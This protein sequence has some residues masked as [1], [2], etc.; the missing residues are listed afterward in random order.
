MSHGA[1]QLPVSCMIVT[2]SLGSGKTTVIKE[3]MGRPDMYGTALIV[4]EF[5]EV[6]LDH[7]LVSSAV[8][9]T[10]LMENG[11]LCCSLRG[12]LVDTIQQLFHSVERA[13]T[14]PF[15]RLIVETTGLADPVP[16]IRDLVT[17]PVLIDKVRLASVCTVVDGLLGLGDDPIAVRQVAQADLCILTKTDLAEDFAVDSIRET[18]QSTNPL[19]TVYLK[20]REPL[21][22][23]GGLFDTVPAPLP[24]Q[25]DKLQPAERGNAHHD[26]HT[27]IVSWSIELDRPLDWTVLSQWFDYLFSL[28]AG[29]ILRMK[30]IVWVTDGDLPLLVQA[31]GP[32]VSPPEWL[33]AWPDGEKR[34]RLVMISETISADSIARSFEKWVLQKGVSDRTDPNTSLGFAD[35]SANG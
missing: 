6:G 32:V 18:L 12:D 11:C 4:N 1:A 13:E 2:G 24:I 8:E 27:D 29:R 28:H 23:T 3:L 31:A 25:S 17:S 30:G 20:G 15:N 14:P 16:I 10:L 9:T 34:T 33:K 26:G 21:P 7:L 19:A 5:G 35:M 22:E